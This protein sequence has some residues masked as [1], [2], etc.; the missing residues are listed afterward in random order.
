MLLLWRAG[1]SYAVRCLQS[2]R[3]VLNL[4]LITTGKICVHMH[5]Y[6]HSSVLYSVPLSDL[7]KH[8]GSYC[9]YM[10]QSDVPIKSRDPSCSKLCAA[11]AWSGCLTCV[12]PALTCSCGSL[13]SWA[14]E[15]YYMLI[16]WRVPGSGAVIT[17]CRKKPGV[18]AMT[19]TPAFLKCTHID[20][21]IWSSFT[22]CEKSLICFILVSTT[23]KVRQFPASM[24]SLFSLK[25]NK[26]TFFLSM[27]QHRF[28]Y[29]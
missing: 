19:T 20:T 28:K 22:E 9:E 6:N 10:S 16:N 3:P 2:V 27:H 17:H 18:A 29:V 14:R 1:C 15:L 11:A 21:V 24:R 5:K 25:W 13:S 7:V 12:S 26:L 8:P 4:N 23:Y